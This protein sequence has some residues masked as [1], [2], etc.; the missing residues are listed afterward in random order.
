MVY[1]H[2]INNMPKGWKETNK[3][4]YKVYEKWRQMLRRCYSDNFHEK[5][6]TYI[7]CTVCERWLTLSNFVEDF[8]HIN[9]YDKEKLLNG[10]LELDKDIK[11]NGKNKEYSLYNCMLVSKTE[12]SRQANKTRKYDKRSEETRYKIS[13]N[14]ADVKGEKHPMSR[15]VVQLKENKLIKIW[16]YAKQA[17]E[18]LGVCSVNISSCCRGKQKTA[19]GYI[20]MYKET[21]DLY[22]QLNDYS[23]IDKKLEYITNK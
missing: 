13:K 9:G 15:K 20:W 21:Y 6:P 10:A 11:S 5:H 18:E 3:W 12:N 16:D 19:K 17:E 14:H 7:G 4:N 1:G 22:Q 23:E 2:G 8:T